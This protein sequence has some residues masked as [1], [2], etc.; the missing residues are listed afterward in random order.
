LDTLLRADGFEILDYL[1]DDKLP[2][3]KDPLSS[4]ASDET[5]LTESQTPAPKWSLKTQWKKSVQD[6]K[7][8]PWTYL[9]IP[10]GAGLVGYITNYVGVKMLFYPVNYFGTSWARWPEEPLG[11]LGW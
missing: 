5:K 4:E 10:I 2:Q 11:L 9:A 7:D 8:R 3:K 1:I 6:V